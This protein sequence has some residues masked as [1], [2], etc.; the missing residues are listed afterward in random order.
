MSTI[1]YSTLSHSQ[2]VQMLK[3]IPVEIKKRE[4]V[5]KR[6]LIRKIEQLAEESGFSLDE[7]MATTSKP[8]TKKAA[9]KYA[10]PENAEQTWTGRGRKPHWVLDALETGKTLED[11]AI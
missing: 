6:D 1:D 11:L 4:K 3:E 9:P 7:V 5:A 8:S 2:L 10:N